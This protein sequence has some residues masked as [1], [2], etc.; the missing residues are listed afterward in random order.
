M[1]GH[2]ALEPQ[3]APPVLSRGVVFTSS[4]EQPSHPSLSLTPVYRSHQRSHPPSRGNAGVAAG[5]GVRPAHG[6]RCGTLQRDEYY[7][8]RPGLASPRRRSQR[9][10]AAGSRSTCPSSGAARGAHG[11]AGSMRCGP[12]TFMGAPYAQWRRRGPRG[13]WSPCYESGLPNRG[14]ARPRR[15]SA[16]H[17]S[18]RVQR[19]HPAAPRG[20]GRL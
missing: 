20:A 12:G 5:V 3:R 4:S 1:V 6:A 7:V 15:R 16:T 2:L 11:T 10:Q 18:V 17:G 9:P 13:A 8:N 19:W 14:Q